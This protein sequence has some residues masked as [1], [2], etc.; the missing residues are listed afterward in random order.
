[1]SKL[2]EFKRRIKELMGLTENKKVNGFGCVMIYLEFPDFEDIQSKI[3]KKDIY[4][5][6]DDP[7]FGLESNPHVTLLYGLHE[8]VTDKQVEDIV[9]KYKF[10]NVKIKN[11]SCFENENFDVLKFDSVKHKPMVDCNIELSKLPNTNEYPDFNP[12]LTVAYLKPKTGKKYVD[13]FKDLKFELKPTKIVYSKTD[14]SEKI[15]KI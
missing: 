3:D 8:E 14:G 13:M 9:T 7:S 12:H 5:D 1:M 2:N 11:I 15:F 6:P 10:S 4:T